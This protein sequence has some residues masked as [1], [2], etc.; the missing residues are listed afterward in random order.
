MSHFVNI[1][2]NNIYIYIYIFIF[3][4]ANICFEDNGKCS[5]QCND[6]DYYPYSFCSC[7][8]GFQL[9]LDG[10][11][12]IPEDG[13]TKQIITNDHI[14]VKHFYCYRPIMMIFPILYD[15]WDECEVVYSY[16]YW[17]VNKNLT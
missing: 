7:Y 13:E 2:E 15:R 16:Y 3:S 10:K 8:E 14:Y 1:N 12:C 17:R 11:T 9:M 4:A 5:Q 6:L